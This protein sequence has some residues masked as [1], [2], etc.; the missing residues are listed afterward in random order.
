[1]NNNLQEIL[2]F[3]LENAPV[4]NAKILKSISPIISVA[5]LKRRLKQLVDLK[6]IDKIGKGKATQYIISRQY[7]L[8]VPINMETYFEKEIDERNIKTSFQSGLIQHVLSDAQIFSEIENEKLAAIQQQFEAK[9]KTLSKSQFNKDLERLAIDLS[10]KSSQIEG[11]TYSLL[12]TEQLIKE[13]QTA[14]GKTKDDANMILNHKTAIDFI[15]EH[16][17]YV[18]PLVVS[19]MEDIHSILIKD[20][21]VERNVRNRK[22]GITGTNYQPLD[23]AF[24]IKEALQE[25]CVLVNRKKDV[26]EKAFLTLILL[27]YIQP[28]HDGNKRTARIICNAIL[29]KNDH[30]PLSF[31]TV[32][33]LHYK[34]AMLL[35]Y[36]Q[37]NLTV[38]K[39]I[40]MEQVEFALETYF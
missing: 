32:D 18:Q 6:L 25:M 31:R 14:A 39:E 16:P 3:I 9:T 24:Q 10:W 4:S 8:F 2:S 35:F 38:M 21:D 23:N 12:E 27:S 15:V 1:M 36:E 13:K 28:F 29:M 33:S 19:A 40:Y 34:K 26:F 7:E 11:N 30:C 37:N 20:L 22:V 17:N 5:T